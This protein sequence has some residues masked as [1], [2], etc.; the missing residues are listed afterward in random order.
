MA[1]HSTKRARLLFFWYYAG[2]IESSTGS[3]RRS[4]SPGHSNRLGYL[5]I[6]ENGKPTASLLRVDQARAESKE[7]GGR[8]VFFTT[9]EE[10][11]EAGA[12]HEAA[13]LGGK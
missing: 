12:S 1:T 8:A 7:M 9:L 5:R 6:A 13:T 2:M 3:D 11:V 4:S 10:A